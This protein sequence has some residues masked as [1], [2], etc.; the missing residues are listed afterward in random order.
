MRCVC[1]IL[2]LPNRLLRAMSAY[3][4]KK[5]VGTGAEIR[6]NITSMHMGFVK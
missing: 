4:E 6:L 5:A 2:T 1:S 3:A